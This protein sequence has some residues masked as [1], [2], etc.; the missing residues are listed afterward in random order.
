MWV[1]LRTTQRDCNDERIDA[2]SAF[3]GNMDW[4]EE[5]WIV[6]SET[7]I[8]VPVQSWPSCIILADV[9]FFIYEISNWLALI[10]YLTTWFLLTLTSEKF[11]KACHLCVIWLFSLLFDTGI[12]TMLL[13]F[14]N[15]NTHTRMHAHTYMCACACFE[16]V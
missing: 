1:R 8:L 9:Y 10:F 15:T 14:S 5:H 2:V 6:S 3:R 16:D 4:Q 11:L 12:L 13:S 7:W